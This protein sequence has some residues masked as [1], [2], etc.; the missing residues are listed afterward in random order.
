[1]MMRQPGNKQS[2]GIAWLK[3]FVAEPMPKTHL[4]LA[5][6]YHQISTSLE[7]EHSLQK[8]KTEVFLS[9]K[10]TYWA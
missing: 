2:W 3:L 6:N 7:E 4:N 8:G 9:C 1:V 10:N 5:G